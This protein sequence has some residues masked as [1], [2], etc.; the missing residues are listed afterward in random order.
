MT[1]CR[2]SSIPL[3]SLINIDF[4]SLTIGI[5]ATHVELSFRVAL[6]CRRLEPSECY[7]RILPHTISCG[8]DYSQIELRPCVAPFCRR[9]KPRGG[10]RR[11]TVHTPTD[12]VRTPK[13]ELSI[14]VALLR[15]R[16]P[17]LQV[18]TRFVRSR[19]ASIKRPHT[20]PLPLAPRRCFDRRAGWLWKTSEPSTGRSAT[21]H[22]VGRQGLLRLHT[23]QALAG[24]QITSAR[25]PRTREDH[26]GDNVGIASLERS[27]GRFR[28]G[29]R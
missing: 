28:W 25:V 10:G 14:G 3:D 5:P 16:S 22:Q 12:Q 27:R 1:V 7:V 13:V 17:L 15:H 26:I 21:W 23:D 4:N 18:L 11:I 8:V 6:I 2:C 20:P 9:L 29:H 24:C 19:L